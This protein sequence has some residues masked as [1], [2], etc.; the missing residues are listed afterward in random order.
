MDVLTVFM[1]KD[2]K[3]AIQVKIGFKV[4]VCLALSAFLCACA[5][6][7]KINENIVIMKLTIPSFATVKV[8]NIETNETNSVKLRHLNGSFFVAYLPAGMYEVS[9]YK[10]FKDV[11]VSTNN[12]N[13]RFV[14]ADKCSNYLGEL[15]LL[16]DYFHSNGK[17]TQIYWEYDESQLY[18]LNSWLINKMKGTSVCIPLNRGVGMYPWEQFDQKFLK[19][20]DG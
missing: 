2:I 14:V 4:I 13:T 19:S 12:E 7:P 18:D 15:N 9:N 10:P 11:V 5:G 20:S 3:L 1:N 17:P 8:R 16:G 6:Q